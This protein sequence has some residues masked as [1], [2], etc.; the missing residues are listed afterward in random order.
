MLGCAA[1][2][3]RKLRW[4]SLL[5]A[6]LLAL[7]L[8]VWGAP[9]GAEPLSE[10]ERDRQA[11]ALSR[12]IMSP[13]CPGRTISACP[14][15][16][17]LEWRNEIRAWVGEGV[18]AD[19]IRR[20]LAARFPRHNLLGVPKNRL[21]WGL[22]IGLAV[23]SLGFLWLLLRY[24]TRRSEHDASQLKQAEVAP[25]ADAPEATQDW[26]ER[27]NQELEALEQQ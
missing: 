1:M 9:A 27:I 21:G 7:G 13:F 25:E 8:F 14:S 6:L 2:A 20:R 17:A 18:P 23:I 24:L 10:V 19:E 15:P 3:E 4:P 11:E 22:P 26:D 5:S 16:L 12:S